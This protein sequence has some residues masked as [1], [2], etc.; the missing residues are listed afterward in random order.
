MLGKVATV[1]GGKTPPARGL[2]YFKKWLVVLRAGFSQDHKDESVE[3][4]KALK[5]GLKDPDVTVLFQACC[6]IAK[7]G[8]KALLSSVA[9]G[10]DWKPGGRPFVMADVWVWIS[11]ELCSH[12]VGTKSWLRRGF[13][14]PH[15]LIQDLVKD[16]GLACCSPGVKKNRTRLG[17]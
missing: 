10:S 12:P 2:G 1:E 15:L 8:Y 5:L 17:H 11:W 16:R 9:S 3:K 13:E 7:V 4:L 14:G 6:S